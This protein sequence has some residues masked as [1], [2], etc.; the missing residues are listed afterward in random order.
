M[1]AP[2]QLSASDL[3][4]RGLTARFFRITYVEVLQTAV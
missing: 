4:D 2:V 1:Y 3:D